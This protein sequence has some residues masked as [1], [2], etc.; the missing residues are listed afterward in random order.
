MVGRGEGG[1]KDGPLFTYPSLTGK[2]VHKILSD[3]GK[4]QVAEQYIHCMNHLK[5]IYIY[6]INICI[7]L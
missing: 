6:M 4:M 7:S 5:I 2:D 1:D 3:G